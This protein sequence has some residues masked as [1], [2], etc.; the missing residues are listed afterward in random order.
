MWIFRTTILC[1]RCDNECHCAPAKTDEQWT[2]ANIAIRMYIHPHQEFSLHYTT[3]TS[4]SGIH[5]MPPVFIPS[6]NK[7]WNFI[8][9]KISDHSR[10]RSYNKM[11]EIKKR[12]NKKL[13]PHIYVNNKPQYIGTF[14]TTGACP[15]I[16]YLLLL[17]QSNGYMSVCREN[18]E[19]TFR[20]TLTINIWNKVQILLLLD[21]WGVIFFL[22]LKIIE[23]RV[24]NKCFIF[25]KSGIVWDLVLR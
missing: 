8:I 25:C 24:C 1:T 13:Q 5:Y 15:V 3:H 19:P 21:Y 4:D 16:N 20:E 10:R 22:L 23:V 17:T 18:R 9:I 6:T 12:P 11:S 14:T 2:G 7:K